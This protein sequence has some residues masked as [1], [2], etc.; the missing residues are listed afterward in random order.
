MKS[1]MKKFTIGAILFTIST[2]TACIKDKN[3]I[4]ST[5][6]RYSSLSSFYGTNG[7]PMQHF[8]VNGQTGG[9]FTT[10]QGT[11]VSIPP[12]CFVDN[13]NNPV[14]G[15]VII[16]F[17]DIYTKSDMLMSNMPPTTYFG[18]PLK[19][20]G[21]FYI[22]AIAN[23]SAIN[24]NGHVP[25]KITQ[26]LNGWASD[27]MMQAFKFALNDSVIGPGPFDTVAC[28]QPSAYDTVTTNISNYI[29]SLYNFSSPVDSG[30]WCNSDNSQYFS[31]YT[32]TKFTIQTTDDSLNQLNTNVFLAFNGLNSLV[33]VYMYNSSFPY[34]FAPLG[35]QCTV[36]A[37]ETR[38]NGQFRAA[39]TPTTITANGTVNFNCT[40]ITTAA[41]KTKMAT[42][43]H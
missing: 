33:H 8:T 35:L 14:T 27:K 18:A 34:S 31:T 32:Q 4:V 7:V 20:G 30:S 43:N 3:P 9:S 29:F 19:S 23:G 11:M 42:Y 26:P 38:A 28:W 24:L 5:T 21:E 39:F 41:F 40:P 22:K 36:I 1:P 10:P 25:I 17:K 6:D 15:N 12:N 2:F 37:I 16:E 13:S